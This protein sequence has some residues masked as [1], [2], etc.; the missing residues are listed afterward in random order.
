MQMQLFTNTGCYSS[1]HLTRIST[2]RFLSKIRGKG[3]HRSSTIV[4][5]EVVDPRHHE[6]SFSSFVILSQLN[7]R[8]EGT[9]LER[10]IFEKIEYLIVNSWKVILETYSELSTWNTWKCEKEWESFKFG[11][12]SREYIWVVLTNHQKGKHW[13]C[14]MVVGKEGSTLV[15]FP[16]RHGFSCRYSMSRTLFYDISISLLKT[17]IEHF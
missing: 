11:S 3:L 2:P 5:L 6:G 9:S 7:W 15:C 4:F 12:Q 16:W 13:M 8:R 14:N 17:V 1:T 10:W